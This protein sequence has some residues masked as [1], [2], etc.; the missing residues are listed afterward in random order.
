VRLRGVRF[1]ADPEPVTDDAEAIAA[2]L[3]NVDM[4]PLLAAVAHLTGDHSIL[5]ADLR[6]DPTRV[7]EPDAGLTAE[8]LARGRALAAGALARYAE[9]GSRPAPEP[10]AQGLGEILRYLVGDAA[11]DGY[12]PVLVEELA[13]GGHDLRAPDWRVDQLAPGRTVTA[14][15]IGAGMSGIV[16][17]HRLRQVGVDVTVVEKN[18]DV[19]GTWLENTFRGCRVDVPSHL[20]SYSFA[21]TGD[22]P[23]FFS[24]QPDL[25]EYFRDCVDELELRPLIRFDTE[26][27]EAAFDE[28][29]QRWDVTVRSGGATE[30]LDA[31]IVVSA[32]GQL[33]RP[34][35]PD[36]V[37]RE[38]FQGVS[39]HSARWPA[40]VDL[41]G[42][43]VGIIGTGASG[44]QFIPPVAEVAGHLT[45][46]Q[47][48]PPWL[49]PTP[50]YHDPV[51]EGVRWVL[52]HVPD[53]ARWDRLWMFWRT[54][55][56]LLPMCEVDE[57]WTDQERSVSE[58]NDV[59]RQLFTAYIQM[60]FPDPELYEK[61]LPRYA[62]VAKRVVRDNGILGRTYRR[63]DV[64]LVTAGIEEITETGVRT[65]DGRHHELD[66]LI[67]GTGFTA[68]DFLVPMHV[69][70][71]DGADLHARWKGDA[72]AYLGMTIPEFP[73]L[74]LMYGPNTNIVINGSII[75]FSE[76]EAHYVTEC[77][78]A[79]VERGGRSL[80][81]KAEVHDAYNEAVD[82]RN[83]SMVWGA[84]SVNSWYKNAQG[85]VSQNWPFSLLEFWQRT[86]T[87][88]PDDYTWR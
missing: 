77:V 60:E 55:E 9:A 18:A 66:V 53:F 50:N 65:A 52:R 82:A 10:D 67:Y 85:R 39:F 14:L 21:Q 31:D 59:I 81:C 36:I 43:R 44:A 61:V 83:R 40:D 8:Q 80:E 35:F 54:H 62:P 46:F 51:P 79:L 74:F 47:R 30:H 49:I 25:L 24:A 16:M 26:V 37:G 56:G 22:W 15:V 38:R 27:L 63:P 73:N 32:V 41:A 69:T 23:S 57:A 88:E 13:L 34:R 11:D 4:P 68:S 3:A 29:A 19:G 70:G 64:E 45:V 33:N 48:T 84:S 28:S 17:A 87:V 86:R 2:V 5:E 58:L 71:V 1:H 72:R 20:Y 6:P 42:K 78:R 76:C 75:Y 12:R 7:L